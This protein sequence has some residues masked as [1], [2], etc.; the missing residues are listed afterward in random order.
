MDRVISPHPDDAVLSLGQYLAATPG[1]EVLTVLAGIPNEG[2]SDY[3]AARGFTSSAD[4]MTARRTEDTNALTELGAKVKFG[5]F[6]D[7]QYRLANSADRIADW[8]TDAFSYEWHT[9]VPLGLGHPDHREIARLCRRVAGPEILLYEELP[10]RVLH[11]E[12]AA[13]ALMVVRAE[14]WILDPLPYPLPQGAACDKRSALQCYAS[15]WHEPD[16]PCFYVPERVWRA[17]R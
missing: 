15:Q 17:T 4:A 2:V 1:C 5:P 12:Q 11:P 10:Y 3:D 16:D 14:G 7:S 9:F 6:Y 13:D 8:L